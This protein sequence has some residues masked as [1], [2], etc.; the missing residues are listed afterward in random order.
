MSSRRLFL[1]IPAV[2]LVSLATASFALA[3]NKGGPGPYGGGKFAA[4][5]QFT[6]TL[7]GYEEVPAVHTKGVGRVTL[8]FNSNNTITFELTYSNLNSPAGAAH[9][10]F[11]QPKVNGGVSFF[12]CGGGGK[13][14]CPPGNTSTPVTV[15]GTVAA[16]DVAALPAQGLAAG[17]LAAIEEEIARGFTYANVHTATSP[18]GE[19]RGQL[20]DARYSGRGYDSGYGWK[21]SDYAG[22]GSG[23]GGYGSGFAG[24]GSGYG[25][26]GYGGYGS[27]YGG[28]GSGY[29]D[30]GSRSCP[31]HG[32]GHGYGQGYDSGKNAGYG[33][34][35]GYGS[36]KNAGY[37][38][39]KGHGF[40]AGYGQ[41]FGSG[42]SNS[43]YGR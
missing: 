31:R 39:G 43:S 24:Y 8:T 21:G 38:P 16:A 19:I 9:V 17:D 41:S 36:G 13:P 34:G 3:S 12:F 14:A 22:Y 40:G 5:T 10:H 42:A 29:D 4:A 20:V 7:T 6:A 1:T 35:W 27:G 32:H 23:H 18:A 37:G 26:S 28:K 11:G 15:T 30:Y 2:L 33:Y 25:G